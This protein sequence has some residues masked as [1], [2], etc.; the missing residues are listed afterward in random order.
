MNRRRRHR[1]GDVHRART[2][3]RRVAGAAVRVAGA[4]GLAGACVWGLVRGVDFL[5]SSDHFALER[6][7][8]SGVH[9][10]DERQLV[11][12]SGLVP[13][14]NVFSLDLASAVRQ[15]EQDPWVRSARA[16][17]DL[18]DA[19]RV[20]VEERKAVAIVSVGG[21]Y[22]VDEL[23]APFKRV[24]A[25]DGLDLPVISGFSR[26]VFTGGRGADD[27]LFAA[28]LQ[29]VDVFDSHPFS[30][31]AALGEL[32]LRDDD[33]EPAFVAFVGDDAV[34]VQLG[35]VDPGWNRASRER[36]EASLGRLDRVWGELERRG[37]R[38]RFIDVGNRLRPEWVAAR[39]DQDTDGSGR[40]AARGR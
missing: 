31:R 5:R 34:E 28:A 37:Q 9:H 40:A 6:V 4:V 15:I 25:K 22:A 35:A 36:L 19:V 20:Q 16:E 27:A 11:R 23:G 1:T 14:A 7:V 21:L 29:V 10:A 18:P 3:L 39:L 17:R 38:A 24:A 12:R 30:R 13:G 32:V 33:G 2:L 8:V 26:D